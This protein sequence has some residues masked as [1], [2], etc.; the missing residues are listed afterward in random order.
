MS[1]Q[2]SSTVAAAAVA[3]AARIG[4]EVRGLSKVQARDA[5]LGEG[6]AVLV[7][8]VS[9]GGRAAAAGLRNGDIILSAAGHD[10]S[11]ATALEERVLA[12][13]PGSPLTLRVWRQGQTLELVLVLA[14]MT[15]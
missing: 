9:D 6:S 10:V 4:L 14:P 12:S 2:A 3:P 11:D 13:V 8:G 1:C 5:G 7:I 15:P